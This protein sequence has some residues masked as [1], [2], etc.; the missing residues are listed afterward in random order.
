MGLSSYLCVIIISFFKVQKG[1]SI[2]S[3]FFFACQI[4]SNLYKLFH[5]LITK[6]ITLNF[7]MVKLIG[8]LALCMIIVC[9]YCLHVNTIIVAIDTD[10][11]AMRPPSSPTPIP[12]A[13]P[14]RHFPV[15][16]PIAATCIASTSPIMLG[17]LK[18]IGTSF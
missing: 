6:R 15:V 17:T 16:V 12:Q 1:N 11:L 8:S 2:L 5:T 7:K 18:N 13:T 3:F 4:E 9:F 14:F 10:L